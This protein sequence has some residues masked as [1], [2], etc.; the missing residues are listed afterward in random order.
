MLLK[1]SR[2]LC[3][4]WPSQALEFNYNSIINLSVATYGNLQL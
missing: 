3:I 1:L 4:M 2:F